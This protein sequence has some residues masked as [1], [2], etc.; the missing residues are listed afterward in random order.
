LY[1]SVVESLKSTR[2]CGGRLLESLSGPD[3]YA[4]RKAKALYAPK[5]VSL[6]ALTAFSG[7]LEPLGIMGACVPTLWICVGR[8][9]KEDAEIIED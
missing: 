1:S 2:L 5:Q 7:S 3:D 8:S 6:R 9:S 4:N